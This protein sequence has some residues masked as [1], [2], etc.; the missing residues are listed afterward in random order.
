[1]E[2]KKDRLTVLEAISPINLYESLY[3]YYKSL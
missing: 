2:E 3:T 1:M